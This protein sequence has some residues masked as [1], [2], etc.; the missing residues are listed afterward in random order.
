MRK[1]KLNQAWHFSKTKR[2]KKK[3]RKVHIFCIALSFMSVAVFVVV[4]VGWKRQHKDV[5]VGTRTV[6]SIKPTMLSTW[7]FQLSWH[8]RES[9]CRATP[10]ADMAPCHSPSFSTMYHNRLWSIT[11]K[12]SSTWYHDRN[13]SCGGCDPFKE[14]KQKK[15]ASCRK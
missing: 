2:K 11:G 9:S 5:I 12:Y 8:S 3:K 14:N 13:I 6:M 10:L 1:A 4:I 7:V 15:T